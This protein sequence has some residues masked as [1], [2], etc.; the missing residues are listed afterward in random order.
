M[1][2][3]ALPLAEH[4]AQIGHA[5]LGDAKRREYFYASGIPEH[6][7]KIRHIGDD[8][9]LRKVIFDQFLVVPTEKEGISACLPIH[10]FHTIGHIKALSTTKFVESWLM[11]KNK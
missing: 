1:R 6:R 7:K 11:K 9:I 3:G 8:L 10:I 4:H 2:N 5:H